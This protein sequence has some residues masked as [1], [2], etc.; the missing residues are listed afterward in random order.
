MVFSRVDRVCP[1]IRTRPRS[2][3]AETLVLWI[4][5]LIAFALTCMLQLEFSAETEADVW[6]DDDPATGNHSGV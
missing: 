3:A 6:L 4:L 2:R 5:C 1:V